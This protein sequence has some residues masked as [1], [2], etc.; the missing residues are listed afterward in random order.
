MNA[1]IATTAFDRGVEPL[2]QAMTPELARRLLAFR[3]DPAVQ[4]RIDELGRRANEGDLSPE[5][6]EEY[7]GYSRAN[8]FIAALQAQARKRVATLFPE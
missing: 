7:E 8:K 4:D 1:S 2:R 5:E 3:P 6:R